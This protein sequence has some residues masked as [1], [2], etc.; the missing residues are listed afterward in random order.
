MTRAERIHRTKHARL[1]R[2]EKKRCMLLCTLRKW[3]R[4]HKQRIKRKRALRAKEASSRA[5]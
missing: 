1:R 2:S 3:A 4:A 5:V